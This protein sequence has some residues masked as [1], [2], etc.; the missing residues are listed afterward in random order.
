M[1]GIDNAVWGPVFW[2]MCH[3]ITLTYPNSPSE[4]EKEHVKQFFELLQYLLPCPYCRHHYKQNL[5]KN[6]LT[7]DILSIKLKL[8]LWFIDIHNYVNRQ[9]GKNEIT[10]EDALVS[11]FKPPY[12]KGEVYKK[13]CDDDQNYTK[14]D[15]IDTFNNLVYTKCNNYV[16]DLKNVIKEKET[17]LENDRLCKEQMKREREL[18]IIKMKEKNISEEEME[19]NKIQ[20]EEYINNAIKLMNKQLIKNINYTNIDI[21]LKKQENIDINKIIDNFQNLIDKEENPKI[22]HL[23]FKNFESV[24]FIF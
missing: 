8:V 1:E 14:Q 15:F 5:T 9:L 16:I 4:E 22:K 19:K 21:E 18:T 2:T 11:L 20:Q 10:I 12:T 13:V 17:D 7:D 6:P 3:Y 24:C 23:I